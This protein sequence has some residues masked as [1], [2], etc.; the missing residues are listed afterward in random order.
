MKPSVA[1]DWYDRLLR[2]VAVFQLYAEECQQYAQ[3]TADGL[4]ENHDTKRIRFDVVKHGLHDFW[5]GNPPVS[6]PNVDTLYRAII[7]S[8]VEATT[9]LDKRNYLAEQEPGT[10]PRHVFEDVGIGLCQFLAYLGEDKPAD[11]KPIVAPPVYKRS[12]RY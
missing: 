7:C 6:K 5:T 11:Y 8:L 2:Q 9:D 1:K 4:I 3:D 12:S 10:E